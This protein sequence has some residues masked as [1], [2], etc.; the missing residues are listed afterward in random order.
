[1]NPTLHDPGV[2]QWSLAGLWALLYCVLFS[3]LSLFCSSLS[4]TGT[5]ILEYSRPRVNAYWMSEFT[6]ERK[7]GDLKRSIQS[8]ACN[9]FQWDIKYLSPPVLPSQWKNRS[10][11]KQNKTNKNKTT[12]QEQNKMPSMFTLKNTERHGRHGNSKEPQPCR[13]VMGRGHVRCVHRHGVIESYS[14]TRHF[15]YLTC[16]K[17]KWRIWHTYLLRKI[18]WTL[19][20]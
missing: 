10:K 15:T 13:M 8:L 20:N 11:G 16:A 18:L 9:W 3:A 5:Q 7:W 14:F 2:P 19:P 4:P 17:W 1:M 6:Q 12:T